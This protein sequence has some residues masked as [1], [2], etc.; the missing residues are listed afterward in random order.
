MTLNT[1]NLNKILILVFCTRF[2]PYIH[3]WALIGQARGLS[4]LELGLIE[5]LVVTS[6]FLL[7][8]PTGILADRIG[9]KWS[10]ALA[11]LLLAC[12]EGIL[13]ALGMMPP[14]PPFILYALV[15]FAA[16]RAFGLAFAGLCAVILVGVGMRWAYAPPDP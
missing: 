6:I 1:R 4:L 8:V 2:H 10:V 14:H 13:L 7:E 12:A 16:T 9:R 5:T 11:L 3:A 15:A